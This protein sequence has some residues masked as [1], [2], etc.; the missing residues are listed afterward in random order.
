MVE[1]FGEEEL[2]L[3]EREAR[4]IAEQRIKDL[5]IELDLVKRQL[6]QFQGQHMD[7]LYMCREMELNRYRHMERGE[8]SHNDIP[9][10]GDLDIVDCCS[11]K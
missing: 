11:Q 7:R 3:K 9:V 1:T 2:C 4:Q 6:S 8:G 10:D 5:V